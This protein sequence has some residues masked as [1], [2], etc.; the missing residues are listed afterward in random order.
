MTSAIRPRD[1]TLNTRSLTYACTSNYI[2]KLYKSRKYNS[3]SCIC[4]I[5]TNKFDARVAY[6]KIGYQNYNLFLF[7]RQSGLHAVQSECSTPSSKSGHTQHIRARLEASSGARTSLHVQD[8]ERTEILTVK[9]FGSGSEQPKLCDV[10]NLSM[11]TRN[12]ANVV[13][14]YSLVLFLSTICSPLADNI[15]L[16]ISLAARSYIHICLYWT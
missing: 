10:V 16:P 7:K 3:N 4:I 2:R 9:T 5:L 8:I 1:S 14:H 15:D 11:Q 6:S 12:G 13:I